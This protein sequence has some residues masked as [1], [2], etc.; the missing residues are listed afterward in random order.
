[1]NNLVTYSERYQKPSETL[2]QYY[3]DEPNDKITNSGSF[4][5]K[6]KW[7]GSTPAAGNTWNNSTT[8]VLK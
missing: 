4:K 5:F 6:T 2:W 8:K 1:M 7:T 3:R